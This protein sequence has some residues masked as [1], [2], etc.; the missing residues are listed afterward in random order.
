MNPK[1]VVQHGKPETNYGITKS[2][3][4]MLFQDNPA[5]MFIWEFSSGN[6]MECNH[7]AL[8]L[9][10]YQKEEFLSLNVK[11]I[12]PKEEINKI[13]S[14]ISDESAFT[15]IG[16][17]AHKG[18]WTHQTKD[19]Q[20]IQVEIKANIIEYKGVKSCIVVVND[21]TEAKKIEEALK[22]SEKEYKRLFN[23]GPL[24]KWIYEPESLRILTVN[25]IAIAH[26]GYSKEEFLNMTLLDLRPKEEYPKL[27]SAIQNRNG[28]GDNKNFGLFTHLK[29]DGSKIK[30]EISSQYVEYLGK[31]CRMVSCEDV[32]KKERQKNLNKLEMDL[33]E[34]SISHKSNNQNYLFDYLAGLEIEFPYIMASLLKVE[35]GKVWNLAAPTL[36]KAYMDA[37]H[38]APIGP[39]AG[40]CGTAAYLKKRIIVTDISK[41]PLWEDYKDLASSFGLK[42]CWSQP[43]FN[44]E[45]EVI[46]TFAC[47]TSMV[48]KPSEEELDILSRSAS[49]LSLILENHQKT[50]EIKSSNERYKYVTLA[51]KDAIYDWDI[52][53]GNILWGKGFQDLFGYTLDSTPFEINQKENLI[54]SADLDEV[55]R[56]LKS[57]FS[58]K[59]QENWNSKY[60]LKKS[61]GGY[62]F[63]EERAYAIRDPKGKVVRMIG[64][65]SDITKET[66][67]E[68][69]LRLAESV[70]KN[71]SDAVVITDVGDYEGKDIKIIYSNSAFTIM[72]GYSSEEVI[73][74]SPKL[75]VGKGLDQSEEETLRKMLRSGEPFETTIISYKKNG[76]E[77][78]NN[79]SASPV[80]DDSGKI[81]QWIFIQRDITETQNE[82]IQKSLFSELGLIFN[83]N[84]NLLIT[85]NMVLEHL[86]NFGNF[87]Y[88]EAWLTSSDKKTVNLVSSF[89]IKDEYDIFREDTGKI[90]SF[91]FGQGLPG[92]V[93]K[94]GKSEIWDNLDKHPNFVRKE[95]AQKTGLNNALGI[96]LLF[97][98]EVIGVILF[99]AGK[100]YKKLTSF[101]SLVGK[102]E[103]FLGSE[104][105]RK[106]VEHQ[107]SGVFNASPDIICIA[108]TDGYF[109]KINLAA[110]ELTGYTEEELLARPFVEFVYPEDL[111]IYQSEF[112]GL[113]KTKTNPYFEIRVISK[114]EKPIWLSWSAILSEEEGLIYAVAKD[115]SKQ[116]ELQELLENATKLSKIGGW[117][118][119]L[120]NQ[121]IVWSSMT[122]E[123]HELESDDIPPTIEAGVNFYHPAYR[124]QISEI[125][126]ESIK[127]GIPFQ[128]EF[129]LIT[130]KGNEKWV[131]AIG[132]PE[133]KNGVCVR[134]L[135]SFQDIHTQKMAEINLNKSIQAI[136]DYKTALDQSFNVT[137]TDLQGIALE[138]NDHTCTLSGYTREELL[139]THTR[140]NKSGYHPKSY[141]Q[142]L[143]QT[144]SKGEIW[145]GDLK[146]KT[147]QGDEYWV[148]T[149]IAPLK[150]E[151]GEIK[152]YLAIRIDITEKKIA[153]ESLLKSYEEKED[154]L[155]SI[156]DAFFNLDEDWHITYWNKKSEEIFSVQREEILGKNIF[157]DFPDALD[158]GVKEKLEDSKKQQ[159]TFHFEHFFHLLNL[160]IEVSVYPNKKGLSVY[161]RDITPQKKYLE[162]I[163]ES[164]SRFEKVAEAT[165]DAI[166]DWDIEGG[167]RFWGEGFKKL[168]GQ[169]TAREKIKV[170]H[171]INSIHPVDYPI[172]QSSLKKALDDKDVFKW[173]EEYRYKKKD[174]KYAFVVDRGIIIRNPEGK[175]I[176]MVGAMSDLTKQKEYEESL[177]LLNENLKK[178]ARDLEVSN[179]EL[180]QFAYIASHDLQEPLRMVSG[181]LTLLEKKYSNVLDAR[182][183][184]YIDFAVDGSIRMRQIILDLLEYSRIGKDDLKLQKINLEEV[185]GEVLLLQ[186]KIIT[187]SGA[188]IRT[189]NLPTITSYSL[190]YTQV[191]NNLINNAVKYSR[192]GIKPEI[193][194]SGKEFENEWEI[195][196][197]DNGIGI[198]KDYF[199]KIFTLFQRLHKKN[200]Y[201]GTGM[202]LSIVKKIIEKQGGKIWVESKFGEGSTFKFTIPK[203]K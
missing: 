66:L 119:D 177:Q 73:G 14:I 187:D 81:S 184:Q 79:L 20:N 42:S 148:D 46:A 202:G 137:V 70:V 172:V 5:P 171:W 55:N 12:R 53:T 3:F 124:K 173:K 38:G 89:P 64:V 51:T 58:D 162:E 157:S 198:E 68:Q 160:W 67:E 43:V 98:N 50:N 128:F 88:S 186:K 105:R 111:K 145:R 115:I 44:S 117:E 109:K 155:E 114:S 151:K 103:T 91:D 193:H 121:K 183:I 19:G 82:L 30:V 76:E 141:Y 57:F 65:L 17:A 125:L 18:Y 200:E 7:A 150:D 36:P 112:E 61:D 139:G 143:W 101:T 199:D 99:A 133:F 153:E 131:R 75:I 49:L 31:K 16:E 108:G 158:L 95:A 97:N 168:F 146:N 181:F 161:L 2:D 11:D 8:L 23:A 32:T 130:A 142:K 175:A 185:V 110:V 45:D 94:H 180:E 13:E 135:G 72:T 196:V 174:G 163:K 21:I 179:S 104:L 136:K 154:I 195:S 120:I 85:L 201:S 127:N 15:N 170:E 28:E 123:I 63:V 166:W 35:D 140:I 203:I 69:Q 86:T 22:T 87:G 6:F 126:E 41:D 106:Q 48:W 84:E 78:W 52:L 149:I 4:E 1:I 10:G 33:L 27:F 39:K 116:K 26:Y 54:H 132:R 96:P 100:N 156:G 118:V 9:Y 56:S 169:E 47:Y 93:W 29:K 192:N 144:I 74:K 102:L 167:K 24:P 197:S 59:K 60:R 129:P 92:I 113:Y 189:K 25:D 165:N 152:Q 77:F 62:S 164:N 182:A 147:K 188:I 107:L 134:L 122:K 90:K 40:S 71:T 159:K 138:V 83:K 34:R 176:R 80:T 37:I 194:V 190:P 178:Q 191:F